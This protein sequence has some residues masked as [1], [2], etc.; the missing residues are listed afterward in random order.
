LGIKLDN[1]N[2]FSTKIIINTYT[3]F[4]SSSSF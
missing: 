4:E 1:L 2:Y 3:K